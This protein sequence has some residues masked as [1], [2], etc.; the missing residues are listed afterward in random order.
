MPRQP[1]GP[2]LVRVAAWAEVPPAAIMALA[3]I[4]AVAA[5]AV[6]DLGSVFTVFLL[7]E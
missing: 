3:M 4:A 2:V 1:G 7:C 5:A 6:N